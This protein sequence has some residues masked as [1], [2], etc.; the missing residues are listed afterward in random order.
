MNRAL[1]AGLDKGYGFGEA[2]GR[3]IVEGGHPYRDYSLLAACVEK[4]IPVTVHVAMGT[5]IRNNFV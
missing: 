5:D 2:I 4:G 1:K 3:C